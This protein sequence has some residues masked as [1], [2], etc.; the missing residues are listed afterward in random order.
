[1]FNCDVVLIQ[2]HG[3]YENII[4][5]YKYYYKYIL[6]SMIVSTIFNFYM[7]MDQLIII[8]WLGDRDRSKDNLKKEGW[9]RVELFD[10]PYKF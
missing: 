1:M 8:E 2:I 4:I 7:Y 10:I 5:D 6:Q 3:S 9:G